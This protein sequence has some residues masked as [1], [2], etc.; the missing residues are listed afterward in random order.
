M[1]IKV[2]HRRES[3]VDPDQ[4]TL[5]EHLAELR[6]R[7]IIAGLAFLAAGIVA[8][9]FYNPILSVLRH[10]YCVTFPGHC[11]L[12]VLSPMEGLGI[13]VKVSAYGGLFLASPVLFW[14]L[15]RFITPGL[16]ANEKRYAVPFILTSVVLFL[17]GASIA[18]LVLPKALGFFKY[19]GGPALRNFYNAPS[20][21]NF[22]L[23]LMAAFGVAFEFPVVLV[24]LQLVNVLTP[25]RLTR[26]RRRA[27]LTIFLLVAI[28]IPTG[29][30]F[31]MLAMAIPLCLFY[32]G[33]IVTGKLLGK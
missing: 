21:F 32:E 11:Q 4:M 9:A 30:P 26:W 23:I 5:V 17:L 22:I 33:S 20:Y 25:A 3:R 27:I 15:W 29:D 16:H 1:A 2:P 14:Q 7:V 19:I 28:F 18:Y 10:P 13:R 24:A 6:R 8:F 12:I 31:S